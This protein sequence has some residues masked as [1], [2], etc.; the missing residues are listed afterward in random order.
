M[1]CCFLMVRQPP[2]A[3]RTDTLFPYTTLF[4]S[5]SRPARRRSAPANGHGPARPAAGRRGGTGRGS[6]N[7]GPKVAGCHGQERSRDAIP[8]LRGRKSGGAKRTAR[9]GRR[10]PAT[11]DGH[12]YRHRRGRSRRRLPGRASGPG[13]DRCGAAGARAASGGIGRP[14]ADGG[15]RKSVVWGKSVSVR[16]ELGGLRL[17]KKKKN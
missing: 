1:L 12:A 10:E 8:V 14:R 16:V 2:R 3:T 7:R 15:D 5:W 17:I 9:I 6:W 11:E 13:R 4:R